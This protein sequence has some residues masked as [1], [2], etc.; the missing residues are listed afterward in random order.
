MSQTEDTIMSATPEQV[1]VKRIRPAQ[2]PCRG[3]ASS[4]RSYRALF[5]I[6]GGII[7]DCADLATYGPMGLFTGMIVGFTVG[8]LISDFYGYSRKGR[9][10]F[11]LLAGIYCT[12]PG[13]FF[14]PLATIFAILGWLNGGGQGRTTEG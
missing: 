12:I 11:S 2:K 9:V 5:P 3:A 14:L 8:W 6:L 4:Q 10:V 1:K 13:T 7:L